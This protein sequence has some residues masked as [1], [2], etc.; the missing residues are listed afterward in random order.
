MATWRELTAE[1]DAW[2]AAGAQAGLWWRDDDAATVTGALRRL[3][4]LGKRHGVPVAL[5]VVPAKASADLAAFVGDLADV[6][7]LQHGIRHRNHMIPAG[8]KI[9]LGGT[10]PR[11]TILTELSRMKAKLEAMFQSR[12]LS[13]LVPPWNRIDAG[14][15]PALPE[16]GF[17]GLSTYGPR[18]EHAGRTGLTWVNTHADLIDWR[19]GRRFKG[20]EAALEELVAHLRAKRLGWVDAREPTGVMSHHLKHD[21]HCWAMLGE[22]LERCTLHPAAR[23]LATREVFALGAP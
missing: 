7:V 23:W 12:F 22:L 19:A 3:V 5:A 11:Q 14:L 8:K 16:L 21:D 17:T 18:Q 4:A 2:H 10:M 15:L 6:C 1:L 13:V 9:E 20:T